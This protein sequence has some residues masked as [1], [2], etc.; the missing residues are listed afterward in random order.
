MPYDKLKDRKRIAALFSEGRVGK[1]HHCMARFLPSAHPQDDAPARV[2]IAIAKRLGIAV[3]RNRIR[4][5]MRAALEEAVL[6]FPPGDYVFLP[7]TSVKDCPYESLL[8]SIHKAVTRLSLDQL[9]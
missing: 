1:A 4:R 5:R 7:R 2:T 6:S 8:K 3:V 9:S